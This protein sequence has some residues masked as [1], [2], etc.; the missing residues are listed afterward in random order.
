MIVGARN[1]RTRPTNAKIKDEVALPILFES[2]NENIYWN[3][4]DIII[5]TERTAAN[6]INQLIM[7]TTNWASSTSLTPCMLE[8][9]TNIFYSKKVPITKF[10]IIP[11][12]KQSTNPTIEYVR[13]LVA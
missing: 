1:T 13:V 3:P 7:S 2:P 5:T 10:T 11:A 4:E 9:S 6:P 8:I 12:I